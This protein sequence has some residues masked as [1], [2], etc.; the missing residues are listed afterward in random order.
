MIV[1][2]VCKGGIGDKRKQLGL[3]W[4]RQR[5]HLI[6][7]KAVDGPLPVHNDGI[8]ADVFNSRLFG[9]LPFKVRN[10]VSPIREK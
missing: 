8:K 6:S 9:D 2:F 5:R 1:R 4:R 3:A 7:S 10:D